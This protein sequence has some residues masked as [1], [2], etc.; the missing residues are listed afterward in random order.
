VSHSFR[1]RAHEVHL[2]LLFFYKLRPELIYIDII[3]AMDAIKGWQV[4][5]TQSVARRRAQRSARQTHE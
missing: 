2:L 5:T 3:F 4:T 1:V